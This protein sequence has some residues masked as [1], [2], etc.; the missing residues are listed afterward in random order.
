M[1]ELS[2]RE[3]LERL[4]AVYAGAVTVACSRRGDRFAQERVC[5]HVL[6]PQE[7]LPAPLLEKTDLQPRRRA[8]LDYFNIGLP[9]LAVC[10][11]RTMLLDLFQYFWPF[12]RDDFETLQKAVQ[13]RYQK[14]AINTSA[15]VAEVAA[16]LREH[17]SQW[18]KAGTGS[19]VLFTWNDFT[20]Q[21]SPEIAAACRESA[22]Q[23][24]VVFKNPTEPPYLCDYPAK[25]KGFKR[26]PR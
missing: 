11:T 6:H 9:E 1:S 24:F 8:T 25:Q 17:R 2:R 23:E 4:A 18:G 21:W 13:I 26:P 19:A 16:Y 15:D 3:F 14:P 10:E 7:F 20:R 22:V 5:I 12:S